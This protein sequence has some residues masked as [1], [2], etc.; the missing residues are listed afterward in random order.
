MD[1]VLIQISLLAPALNKRLFFFYLYI[2]RDQV[3]V[4]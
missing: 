2:F 3:K 4:F 1:K